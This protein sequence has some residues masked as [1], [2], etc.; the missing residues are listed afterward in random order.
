MEFNMALLLHLNDVNEEKWANSLSIALAPYAVLKRNDN[1]NAKDINYI[2][3]WKA[4]NNAFDNLP[5]LKAVFSLGAGVDALLKHENLPKN[6]PI[7]RFVD[8]DLSQ[9]MSDYVIAHVL[10]HHR[11]FTHYDSEQKTKQWQQYF[12]PPASKRNVGIMGLG[13]LGLGAI[14]RLKPLGF[15]L[16]GWS[17]SA[18]NIKDVKSYVGVKEFDTFL[19]N[20]DI[21]VNLLPLTKQTAHI[22]NYENFKKLKRSK[23]F[24]P[25]I[26]NAARGGHQ[27]ETD[28]IK[29]LNDSTLGAA[30]LDVFE[31]EPLPKDSP[32]W[33]IKNCYITPHIAAISNVQTGVK[34]FAKILTDHEAGKPLINLVDIKKGY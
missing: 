2:F 30:S 5:N 12:P 25:V 34:Y 22:L 23:H 28:I 14:K 29:A 13:E 3:A 31:V 19:A 17:N 16:H 20:T 27:K 32:L 33:S 6:V 10:M 9:C 24:A 18:K 11:L 1:Y 4:D 26:I 15:S 21:L 7:V 8:K